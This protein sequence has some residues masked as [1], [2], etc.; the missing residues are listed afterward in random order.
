V[1]S[2]S[3]TGRP[4]HRTNA[5]ASTAAHSGLVAAM[6]SVPAMNIDG[7]KMP[8]AQAIAATRR[9]LKPSSRPRVCRRPNRT[10][11]GVPVV[12]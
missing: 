8:V 9:P 4:P 6:P 2:V 11:V 10:V 5:D 3:I 1:G 7:T 12:V